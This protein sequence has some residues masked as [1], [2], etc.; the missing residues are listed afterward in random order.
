MARSRETQIRPD[1]KE[2]WAGVPE[3]ALSLIVAPGGYGKTT[4]ARAWRKRLDAAGH[5]VA[6]LALSP[7]H[8]DPRAF[9]EDLLERL[10]DA[11]PAR[12]AEEP[13]FGEAVARTLSHAHDL[14][15]ERLVRELARELSMLAAPIVLV[16]DAFESLS[17]EGAASAI[18]DGLLRLDRC[19]LCVVITTRGRRP[20]STARLLAEGRADEIGPD[21]LSLRADQIAAMARAEGIE[22]DPELVA[23][24]LARTEGWAIAIRLALR[25]I[26]PLPPARRLAFVRDSGAGRDLFEYVAEELL[27]RAT[28]DVIAVLE[29]AALLGP[30]P[31][32]VL[33][34]ACETSR[35]RGAGPFD[36]TAIDEAIDSGLLGDDGGRLG[37]HELWRHW[38]GERMR[39]R[40]GPEVWLAA[41][42]RA[43]RALETAGW[44]EG[45]IDHYVVARTRPGVEDRL[46]HV[47]AER[48]DL[49]VS[50][51]RRERVDLCLDAI[52]A[53]R[54]R[55]EPALVALDG[56][57]LSGRDPDGA[58]GHLA[59]AARAYQTA[60]NTRAEFMCL[61]ELAIV[62]INENRVDEVT[63]IFRR[64]LTLRKVV[65]E[66]VIRAFVVLAI[67]QGMMLLGRYRASLRLL[68]VAQ[69]YDHHP[70]ERGGLE[71][72]RSAILYQMG[73]WD[74]ASERIRGLL[75]R[76]AQREHGV[77]F[78]GLQV[79]L[80]AIEVGRGGDAAAIRG[81]LDQAEETFREIRHTMTQIRIAW[82]RGQ[83]E[84]REGDDGAAARAFERALALATRTGFRE[85]EAGIAGA[86]ARARLRQ[87]D[88]AGA[89][90]I[91][92]RGIARLLPD[93][94]WSRSRGR[95][96]AWA[97]GIALLVA[98]LAELGEGPRAMAFLDAHR[99][100]LEQPELPL[101]QHAV[102]C[103]IARAEL[104]TGRTARGERSLRD[105]WRVAGKASLAHRAP[106]LDDALRTWST[107]EAR[108]RGLAGSALER[109]DSRDPEP[110]TRPVRLDS[111]G[112]LGIELGGRRV[113][114]RAWRG[115]TPRRLLTR[116][117][118][119]EG[120]AVARERLEA[121]LWPEMP[122]ARAA[123]N[124]RVAL[125]RL[126]DVLEPRR[127]RDRREVL[128]ALEDRSVALTPAAL[129]AW[130]VLGARA[131]LDEIARA[132]H[133]A[134]RT[135]VL[136][137]AERY[138]TLHTG[139]F[140]PEA[141]DD[142]V[143]EYRRSFE[144]ETGERLRR[145]AETWLERDE[146]SGPARV[147][148]RLALARDGAD[149]RAWEVF[150][151][152]GL[153]AGDRTAAARAYAE[154]VR[155]LARELDAE[156]GERLRALGERAGAC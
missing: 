43:G 62:A 22:P 111:L 76:P 134:D 105:A 94:A 150:V 93:E 125:S 107:E 155:A 16:L 117:L 52:D 86:L 114:D 95:V 121:D 18:V 74:E 53:T 152:A 101:A 88:H 156:P 10:R 41:H 151:G 60:G 147:L 113:R 6:W 31:R 51:G 65:T 136:S 97:P 140:L 71:I 133:A 120:R 54:R 57:V 91:A 69:T 47:L 25:A 33:T 68:D 106:E 130:D 132:T 19:P 3:R 21:A 126:R 78:H 20:A 143:I 82:V 23:A 63:A 87:G 123:N 135:G 70:R 124:L 127:L 104:L 73:A 66:P 8:D 56:L 37:L 48:G 112:G 128:I 50:Q 145:L 115:R 55:T 109:G 90:E 116:L 96:L 44:L 35:E 12:P 42:E 146:G 79:Y 26:A 15:A 102:L 103:A 5:R 142:W 17:R 2:C 153:A 11:L 29:M 59:D 84:Q 45:A 4:L 80:A 72:V 139:P 148:A 39:E 67:G 108:A 13:A 49:W 154:A 138:R 36:A 38:L 83:L 98:T 85:A 61:H 1:L 129:A 28:P 141:Y 110:P 9:V 7:L 77:T 64:A 100:R 118:V 46:V 122:P 144:S 40:D 131:A 30:V 99:R 27:A 149:E 92:R 119:A 81:L 32:R 137:A 58:I 14:P 89:L 34:A 24:L 75:A